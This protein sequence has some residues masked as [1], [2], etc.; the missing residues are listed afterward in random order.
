M[1]HFSRWRGSLFLLMICP[2][3]W[4]MAAGDGIFLACEGSGGTYED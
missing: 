4:G 1:D 2:P 3:V